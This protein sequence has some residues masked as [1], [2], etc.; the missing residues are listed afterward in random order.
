M[1]PTDYFYHYHHGSMAVKNF[2]LG[3][4]PA[5]KTAGVM[6]LTDLLNLFER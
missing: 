3:F 2:E 5:L 4:G 6:T 1:H